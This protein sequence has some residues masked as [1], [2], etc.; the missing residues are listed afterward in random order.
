MHNILY[1]LDENYNKQAFTSIVSLLDNVS[2][3]INIFI[4]HKNPD[5]FKNLPSEIQYHNKLNLLNI[6]KFNSEGKFFPNLD[7]LFNFS[8]GLVGP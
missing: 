6:I 7:T 1:C 5:T 2:E 3:K 8:P 4:I